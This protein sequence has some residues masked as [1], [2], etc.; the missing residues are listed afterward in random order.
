MLYNY[1]EELER[2]CQFKTHSDPTETFVG[3]NE[4]RTKIQTVYSLVKPFLCDEAEVNLDEILS[5]E[6]ASYM[7][8]I[9]RYI[10]T[11]DRRVGID[12]QAK[13]GIWFN[14]QELL[15]KSLI[16]NVQKEL[17]V[18]KNNRI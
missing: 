7:S 6:S 5:E 14:K 18:S 11:T 15:R 10:N 2:E 12:D 3:A 9:E 1:F 13:L 16:D 17:R 8:F 4:V